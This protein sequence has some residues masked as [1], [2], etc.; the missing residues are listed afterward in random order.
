VYTITPVAILPVRVN[1]VD[2]HQVSEL[3]K[4]IEDSCLSRASRFVARKSH[5][6]DGLDA[7]VR[8]VGSGRPGRTDTRSA[9]EVTHRRVNVVQ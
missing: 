9:A 1:D 3:S 7:V 4:L 6:E 5:K 8:I 2:L